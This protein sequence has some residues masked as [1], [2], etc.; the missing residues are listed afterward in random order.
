MLFRSDV[1]QYIEGINEGRNI[2]TFTECLQHE[3]FASETVIMNLRLRQGI[4]DKDF[5]DRF[6]Y[7][8]YDRFG[9]LINRLVEDGLISYDNETLKLTDKGLY[10][11]DTVMAEF[12]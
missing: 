2:K 7:K 1:Y 8:I 9:R 6:G 4:S 10:L 12:L 5:H 3:H 11:A